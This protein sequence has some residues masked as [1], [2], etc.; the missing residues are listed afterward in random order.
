MKILHFS[1]V[2]GGL[3]ELRYLRQYAQ[4]LSD[5]ELT[6]F[7]GDLLGPFLSQEQVQQM[8]KAFNFILR[9]VKTKKPVPVEE[10]LRQC[11]F[12][13]NSTNDLQ[14]AAE[15]YTRVESEFDKNAELRYEEALKEIEQF[16]GEVLMIPGNWDI[17]HFAKIFDKYDINQK[18]KI[19][20]GV[21]IAGYGGSDLHPDLNPPTRGTPYND[22]A[23]YTFLTQEDPDI[24][25]TH[26]PPYGIYD[27]NNNHSGR[28]ANLAYLR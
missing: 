4:K 11:R 23:L 16:P 26:V 21:K 9:N 2:H 25:I 3:E 20:N 7:S 14:R 8:Y 15:D 17:Q 10:I 1:D 24:A 22:E 12:N 28:F 18:S 6:I 13:P 27:G 19:V 5:F